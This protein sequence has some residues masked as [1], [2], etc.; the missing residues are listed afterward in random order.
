VSNPYL[1]RGPVRDPDMLF[2]RRHELHE[3][4]AFVAASQSVSIVGP[5]KI[6]K[7]SL[8]YSLIRPSS[9]PDLR[10]E[11]NNLFVY[12]D[13]EVLGE[14]AHAEI[15]GQFAAE[16]IAAL[17]ERG[18]PQE[19]ALE[20]AI[21]RPTRLTF[22]AAVRKLNQ[23]GLR[24]TLILD[25]FERLSINPQ[26][27]VNFFNALRSIAGRYQFVF[28]TA[29][30]R[31]LIE[32][33]Y[34]GRSQEI[35][36]S[37]FFNIFAPVF[38]GLLANEDA[39]RLMRE[40]MRKAGAA[41]TSS[42][43]DFLYDLVGGHPLGLQVA[44]FH[45]FDVRDD[46][47]EIE[48]RTLRELEAHFAY[49]WHNLTPAEQ[50]ALRRVDAAAALASCDTAMRGLLRDLVQKCLLIAE[51]RVENASLQ[52]RY[53]S[54]AWAQFVAVQ[55]K[56]SDSLK[57]AVLSD[58]AAPSHAGDRPTPG[59]ASAR[60]PFVGARFGPYKVL[61]PLGR[62][63]MAEVYRGIH[64]RLGRVVAIKVLPAGL[65]GHADFRERFEREARAVAALRH[66]NIVQVYDFGDSE[67][68]YYMVMEYIAGSDLAQVLMER[69]PLP[70]AQAL[71]LLGDVAAALDY[72][73]MQ[74]L[75]HRDIK[76]S[77]VMIQTAAATGQG[78]RA[79]LTDFGIAKI[80][81]ASNAATKTGM[82]LGTL[83]YMAP[84]QIRAAGEVDA[85]A[86]VYALGVMLFQMLTGRLPFTG[87]NPG[88]VV[89]AH[90]SEP[91]PDPRTLLPA[92]P[93]HVALAILR[94]LAKEPAERYQTAGALAAALSAE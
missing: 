45:A 5:R 12:L 10:L 37:P 46:H 48:R 50:D 18:L 78:Q 62:G 73:H 90:L 81:A 34:S 27:D 75:V 86:D 89:L 11:A 67:G 7:T 31:P 77:N 54:R 84:E 4:A 55:H 13:C 15:F 57:T 35:L 93:D 38:L 42:T 39:Y 60:P 94:A 79:I 58:L 6:G 68:M 66:T 51:G 43:E 56:V 40:P 32:L 69:G 92:L 24:V 64:T 25:E 29:S 49:T 28:L 8:I 87:E 19:P 72:A 82:M 41:F 85:R 1:S 88:T 21:A 80:L 53:P 59:A 44:S 47:A 16:M 20:V 52:Y 36:S 76:P 71:P 17:E 30:A 91:P 63:G 9:W 70:L 65:A 23:R 14:G 33:T 26:L 74:G 61:E 83:D 2:G 22:E 3:I